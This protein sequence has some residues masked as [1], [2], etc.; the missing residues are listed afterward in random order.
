MLNSVEKFLKFIKR[1]YWDYVDDRFD[2][3]QGTEDQ[4]QELKES[5]KSK[6]KRMISR[7]KSDEE[8][9]NSLEKALPQSIQDGIMKSTAAFVNFMDPLNGN[10][11]FDDKKEALMFLWNFEPTKFGTAQAQEYG[12]WTDRGNSE[13]EEVLKA[14]KIPFF[15][16]WFKP[17]LTDKGIGK[18]INAV[19]MDTR[20]EERESNA[21]TFEEEPSEEFEIVGDDWWLDN[22]TEDEDEQEYSIPP[23]EDNETGGEQQNTDEEEKINPDEMIEKTKEAFVEMIQYGHPNEG[24]YYVD[25]QNNVFNQFYY[26]DGEFSENIN[27]PESENATDWREF[28]ENTA[29]G[30]KLYV[31]FWTG[32]TGFPAKGKTAQEFFD[33]LQIV[34]AKIW[35]DS[36]GTD[37]PETPE[38]TEEEGLNPE[39]QLIIGD[40][41][42]HLGDLSEGSKYIKIEDFE[43]PIKAIDAYMI[44]S[45]PDGSIKQEE[46]IGE[47][48]QEIQISNSN[49][50]WLFNDV[51]NQ[52]EQHAPYIFVGFT[53]KDGEKLK[54]KTFAYNLQG[55]REEVIDLLKKELKRADPPAF[56]GDEVAKL[57]GDSE[58]SPEED[59]E[60]KIARKLKP[61]I[62]ELMQKGK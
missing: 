47:W 44:Y 56:S 3:A 11:T 41:S 50:D 1:V 57:T 12:G 30:A 20:P 2:V 17:E 37:F 22:E 33:S 29:S 48:K 51:K 9:F 52:A 35:N 34:V 21:P 8:F 45:K 28:V 60:E 31:H 27:E 36:R 5:I 4:S 13:Q 18:M 10:I 6:I 61:L 19:D 16:N 62:R 25:L 46:L 42:D 43:E 40:I 32:K 15:S 55:S 39:Q 26:N 23:E 7:S 14:Y 49:Y 24:F 54:A 58:E 38:P 59:L 53:Y